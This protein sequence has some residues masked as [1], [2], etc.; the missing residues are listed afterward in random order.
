MHTGNGVIDGGVSLQLCCLVDR[1][2]RI[3]AVVV[4]VGA[5]LAV[6]RCHF[7]LASPQPGA[8]CLFSQWNVDS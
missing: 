1:A 3:G 4:D 2:G 7:G 5:L 8:T 6:L